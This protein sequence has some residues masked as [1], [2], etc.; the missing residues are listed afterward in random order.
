MGCTLIFQEVIYLL[1]EL[2]L[3]GGN[4]VFQKLFFHVLQ[5]LID[6]DMRFCSQVLAL[7]F[8]EKG[9][10][11]NLIMFILQFWFVYVL[12]TSSKSLRCK[13]GFSDPKLWNV[14]KCWII[15]GLKLNRDAFGGNTIHDGA[16]VLVGFM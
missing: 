14:R 9:K 12:Q 4:S 15:H 13:Y 6:P 5:V 3:W 7:S 2:V 10:N 1:K 16:P 11:F 8:N